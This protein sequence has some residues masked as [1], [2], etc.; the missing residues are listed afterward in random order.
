MLKPPTPLFKEGDLVAGVP[1]AS[2]YVQH[3]MRGI[4]LGESDR[5]NWWGDTYT[6]WYRILADNGKIVEEIEKYLD[7]I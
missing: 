2:E 1:Y 3:P 5:S 7:A 6:R 4:I